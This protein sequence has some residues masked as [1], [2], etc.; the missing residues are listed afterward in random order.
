MSCWG[1][2][3]LSE[4][5]HLRVRTEFLGVDSHLFAVAVG[6]GSRNDHIFMAVMAFPDEGLALLD[7]QESFHAANSTYRDFPGTAAGSA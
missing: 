4:P 3:V 5:E 2:G 1:C 7:T 6:V